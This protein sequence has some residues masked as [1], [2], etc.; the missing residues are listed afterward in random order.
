VELQE[1]S[2]VEQIIKHKELEISAKITALDTQVFFKPSDKALS[3]VFPVIDCKNLTLFTFTIGKDFAEIAKES[4]IK[5]TGGARLVFSVNDIHYSEKGKK[6]IGEKAIESNTDQ[7][8]DSLIE[9]QNQRE[10]GAYLELYINQLSH[11]KLLQRDEH[12]IYGSVNFSMAS[13]GPNNGQGYL[14]YD[15]LVCESK[16]GGQDVADTMISYLK[17]KYPNISPI[18]LDH[19]TLSEPDLIFA[20]KSK[21]IKES[22][23][24]LLFKDVKN[25]IVT[26]KYADKEEI[27][28]SLK[29]IVSTKEV[30]FEIDPDLKK[31]IDGVDTRLDYFSDE[32]R[33]STNIDVEPD[34]IGDLYDF[35]H[36]AIKSFNESN[37][38]LDMRAEEEYECQKD[39][40]YDVRERANLFDEIKSGLKNDL[41]NLRY[42]FICN[43]ESGLSDFF[44]DEILFI[45]NQED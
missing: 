1:R 21:V 43:F 16:Q 45:D 38:D 20:L 27:I 33:L 12:M 34:L 36:E 4:L 35:V 39:N 44:D 24:K 30:D 19:N 8:I 25:T 23:S 13:D 7:I 42:D 29:D 40:P 15:E 11:I 6:I 9:I 28:D 5:C 14:S 32:L 41:E 18:R 3:E 26:I 10:Y 2:R 37:F 17:L 22:S 31:Y